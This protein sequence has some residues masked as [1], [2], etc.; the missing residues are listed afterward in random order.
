M[1]NLRLGLIGLGNIGQH[2]AA[3]LSAGKIAGAELVAVS[4]AVGAKLEKYKPLKTFESA[5]AL[6]ASDL[7]YAVLIATPH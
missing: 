7:V 6:I 2:H 4:D 1:S 3:Y 5:E